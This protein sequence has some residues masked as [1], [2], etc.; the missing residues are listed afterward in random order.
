M[1]FPIKIKDAD[2]I[3][4]DS[5]N[6]GAWTGFAVLWLTATPSALIRLLM[7]LMVYNA[8]YKEVIEEVLFTGGRA[9]VRGAPGFR[10]PIS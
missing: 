8:F 6:Y 5:Q 9:E 1:V 3:S 10:G 2:I 4:A 7:S